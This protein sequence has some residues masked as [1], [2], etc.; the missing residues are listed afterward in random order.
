[1]KTYI[2]TGLLCWA[3]VKTAA[4]EVASV[5]FPKDRVGQEDIRSLTGQADEPLAGR[6][7]FTYSYEQ[8]D[9]TVCTIA[10]RM[11]GDS[12]RIQFAVR[13]GILRDLKVPESVGDLG[14]FIPE[15]LLERRLTRFLLGDYPS[16][17]EAHEVLE[18]VWAAGYEHAFL[19]KYTDGIRSLQ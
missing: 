19:V 2:L 17:E 16:A 15:Y 6:L 5:H 7:V 10:P 3:A 1:M 14:V 4:Q 8:E 11:M 18:Q 12:W 13:D 9:A